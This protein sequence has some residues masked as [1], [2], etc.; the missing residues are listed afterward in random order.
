[1][2]GSTILGAVV[3]AAVAIVAAPAYVMSQTAT[4][5]MEQKAKGAAQEVGTG[6]SDSWLT[7]KTKI[8]LFGDER[9]KGTQVSVDTKK[10][11]VHLRGKVDSDE[12]KQAAVEVAKAI[13]GTKSVKNDL[14][15]VS[16]AARKAV[17]AN[18]KDITKA[19]ESRMSKAAPLKKVDVRTDGGV[20]TLT[21][22]VSSITAAAKASELARYVPGVKWVKNEL[23]VRQANR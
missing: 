5:T 7:A 3:V 17:D 20:V 21:G 16:P 1:M 11:V 14:Q 22:E 6:I 18:D 8:A 2:R 23:T 12:A 13:E 9:V 19:V 4:G 15:V 10:G